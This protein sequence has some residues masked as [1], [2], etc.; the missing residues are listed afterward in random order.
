MSEWVSVLLIDIKYEYHVELINH[1]FQLGIPLLL[2]IVACETTLPEF[3]PL[4][5]EVLTRIL[6]W[7]DCFVLVVDELVD[8]EPPVVDETEEYDPDLF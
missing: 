4:L 6:V 3:T 2:L 1:S 7:L 8:A 5:P